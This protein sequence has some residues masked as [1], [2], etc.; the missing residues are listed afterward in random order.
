MGDVPPFLADSDL[1]C[2][3]EVPSESGYGKRCDAVWGK[4]WLLGLDTTAPT[5]HPAIRSTLS[6]PVGPACNWLCAFWYF[7]KRHILGQ[8]T[9]APPS[10]M[11]NGLCWKGCKIARRLS[12]KLLIY[13]LRYFSGLEDRPKFYILKRV[14]SSYL[15]CSI[16]VLPKHTNLKENIWS[17]EK[18]LSG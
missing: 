4:S 1:G 14:I 6:S 11:V 10:W 18:W 3:S 8:Q 7:T 12:L 5:T 13:A 2:L 16:T 9:E 15:Y 17:L